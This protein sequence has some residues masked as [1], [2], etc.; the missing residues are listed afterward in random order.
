M[1]TIFSTSESSQLGEWCRKSGFA[2]FVRGDL[3]TQWMNMLLSTQTSAVVF[4]DY[5]LGDDRD[6][7]TVKAFVDYVCLNEGNWY[8]APRPNKYLYVQRPALFG[9]QVL[10]RALQSKRARLTDLLRPL[11]RRLPVR[12]KSA[13][14]WCRTSLCDLGAYWLQG[15]SPNP[16]DPKDAD[17]ALIS[18]EPRVALP[19]TLALSGSQLKWA[20]WEAGSAIVERDLIERVEVFFPHP[21]GI[22][23][24]LL[25]K[26][27]LKCVMCP[28]HSPSYKPH[29]LND[30][31]EDYKS[32]SSET[33]AKI[34]EYAGRYNIALQFGQIEEPLMHK[35]VIDFLALARDKGVKQMHMTTNGALLTREKSD[36]LVESGL[37]SL[38]V[39]IDAVT[40]ETYRNIR[41][42][43]LEEIERNISY[44]V[45]RAKSRSIKVWVSFILQ[46]QAIAEREAFLHK[47]HNLGVDRVT[48]YVLGKHD[49]LTGELIEQV[50]I[51]PRSDDR[52]PCASPWTQSVVFPEGQVSLCCRTMAL[53]GW[54]GIVDV[55]TIATARDFDSIWRGERY[56]IVRHELLAGKFDSFPICKDCEIWSASTALKEETFD[57][58]RTYN[59]TMETYEFN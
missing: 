16:D 1:L 40:A 43:D 58:I 42:G 5:P 18:M 8:Y 17:T 57:Y 32:M 46:P 22:H 2:Y 55:G 41:G 47:W 26:C 13:I 4:V 23:V 39:S 35:N 45:G 6:I 31:F 29:H 51:Y 38:M 7:E 34:A 33:F 12:I 36:A 27:N 52:Y 15:E 49:Q 10:G 54:Q 20:P 50:K 59:E 19:G 28:Y 21:L 48:F 37:T 53:L 11:Y 44:F 14:R 25:N 24:I 30:Y 9:G 56:S 3:Q